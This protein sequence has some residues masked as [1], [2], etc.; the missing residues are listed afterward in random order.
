MSTGDEV[1]IG[2]RACRIGAVYASAI[3]PAKRADPP[4]VPRRLVSFDP[5]FGWPGG[6]V[7]AELLEA[8]VPG[9]RPRRLRMSGEGWARWAGEEAEAG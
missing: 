8:P 2:G 7:V 5:A 6:L 4:R 9:R 1:V 3:P